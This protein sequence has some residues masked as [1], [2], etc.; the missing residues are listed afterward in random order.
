[1]ISV[2]T[3]WLDD[4]IVE[5]R[6]EQLKK[7]KKFQLRQNREKEVGRNIVHEHGQ[8][9]ILGA[10][11]DTRGFRLHDLWNDDIDDST[12]TSSS[13][14]FHVIEVDQ[15]EVQ[16]K[17]VSYM[18]WLMTKETNN[19]N[20]NKHTTIA[21]LMESSKVSFLP[22]NFV[23]DNLQTKLTS[24]PQFSQDN[25]TLSIITMEGVTQ[26]IPR[27]ATAD[28]LKKMHNIITVG[29]TL[30]ITYVDQACFN[31]AST[32]STKARQMMKVTSK[33]GEPW[34]TGFTP[35]EFASLLQECG[36][37]VQSDTTLSDYNEEYL[38]VVGRKLSEEEMI[39]AER[40]VV[41]K[42]V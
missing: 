11:Y 37:Q 3:R 17:K 13:T 30:L 22:V 41:A 10:G 1:M 34:I 2:R 24:H 36:Y 18:K 26:Y 27:E 42:V 23:T 32:L 38:E 8:L 20:S 35:T 12:T 16:Q 28:T 29:S 5:A 9:I 6:K 25:T 7:K 40:F 39:C 15:P 19:S 21:N 33:V 14:L 31:D 4:R